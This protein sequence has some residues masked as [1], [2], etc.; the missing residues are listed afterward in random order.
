VTDSFIVHYELSDQN[1]TTGQNAENADNA[2]TPVATQGGDSPADQGGNVTHNHSPN[3]PNAPGSNAA[4]AMQYA[5]PPSQHSE[6]TYG[7]PL[8]FR[9]LDDIFN[10]TE[11]LEEYEYSGVCLLAADEPTSVDEALE[12][13]CWVEAMTVN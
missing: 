10:N 4:P 2:G 8:R 7:G 12:D 9:R 6:D 1:P 3:S 5:T 13:K 11:E